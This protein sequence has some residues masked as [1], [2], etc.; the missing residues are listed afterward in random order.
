MDVVKTAVSALHGQML[1]PDFILYSKVKVKMH[2]DCLHRYSLFNVILRVD[3][4]PASMLYQDAELLRLQFHNV[5]GNSNIGYL[6][7]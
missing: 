1:L 3:L 6:W 5:I 2:N 7:S 4:P